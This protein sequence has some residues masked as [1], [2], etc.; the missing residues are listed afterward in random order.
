MK[1]AYFQINSLSQVR[2][3]IYHFWGTIQSITWA[4]IMFECRRRKKPEKEIKMLLS[5]NGGV[6]VA[7]P[8]SM[9]RRMWLD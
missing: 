7:T 1:K 5:E 6:T 3:W 9:A 8:A 2:I 4:R